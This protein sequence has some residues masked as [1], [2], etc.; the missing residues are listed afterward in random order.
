MRKQNIRD[1]LTRER[2]WRRRQTPL[3]ID[4]VIQ[5]GCLWLTPFPMD[6]STVVQDC[7]CD[8][9]LHQLWRFSAG[10]VSFFGLRGQRQRQTIGLGGGK[11][12]ISVAENLD[13]YSR[14]LQ[15][16]QLKNGPFK[17]NFS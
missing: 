15:L 9:F 13:K 7:D 1:S 6:F 3:L 14:P 8:S 12:T 11:K 17:T 5:T 10:E 16:I 2:L 4:L